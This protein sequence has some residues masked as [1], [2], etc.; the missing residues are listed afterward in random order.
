MGSG[1]LVTVT[2]VQTALDAF[3]IIRE[4]GEGSEDLDEGGK[5]R[6]AEQNHYYKFTEVYEDCDFGD[7]MI[8]A[9]GD[10][11]NTAS[12]PEDHPISKANIAF[13]VSYCYLLKVL[14]NLYQV[15]DPAEKYARIRSGVFIAMDQ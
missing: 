15:E 10:V 4:Q 6:I 1:G 5:I 9:S 3:E 13:N 14:D 12:L 2:N 7:Q 8:N 11:T